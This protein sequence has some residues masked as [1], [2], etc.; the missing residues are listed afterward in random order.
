MQW[1]E[2]VRLVLAILKILDLIPKEKRK[3]AEKGA[4]KAVAKVVTDDSVA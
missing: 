4:F 3:E 1:Y 2:I